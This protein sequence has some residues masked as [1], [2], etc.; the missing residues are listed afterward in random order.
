MGMTP[1]GSLGCIQRL[2]CRSMAAGFSVIG[3]FLD[4]LRRDVA[5]TVFVIRAM[6]PAGRQEM[7]DSLVKM[8]EED[9][10]MD[11]AQNPEEGY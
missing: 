10:A 3:N 1:L 8:L 7:Y 5:G 6:S 4:G 2:L 9:F 11:Q